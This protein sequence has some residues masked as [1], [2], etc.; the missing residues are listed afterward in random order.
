M[1]ACLPAKL[2]SK[3]L[4]LPCERDARAPSTRCAGNAGVP[5]AMPTAREKTYPHQGGDRGD[6]GNTARLPAHASAGGNR[7]CRSDSVP[8]RCT[9][10]RRGVG[11]HGDAPCLALTPS[12]SPTAWAR[13]AARGHVWSA[14]ALA[15]A[16][17]EA[18]LP[19]SIIPLSRLAQRGRFFLAQLAWRARR[20]RSQR[21]ACWERE[22]LARMKAE[23][24]CS[25]TPRA[26][27]PAK[28]P[29][30]LSP[31]QGG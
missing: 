18:S 22:R 9:L 16:C 11:T 19:H 13:G 10:T 8:N 7:P 23:T 6:E 14:E 12:P 5:P 17:A 24:P 4:L 2:P 31:C 27:T 29:T 15:S 1:L 25:A 21:C 26:G 3:G 28:K 30:P 20:P